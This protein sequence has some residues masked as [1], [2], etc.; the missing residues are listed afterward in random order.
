MI[1]DAIDLTRVKRALIIKLRHHGDVLLTSPVIQVLKNHAPHMEIDALVYHDTRE[2]LTNHPALH[3]LHTIDRDWKRAGVLTQW[4]QEFRLVKALLARRYDLV[5]HLTSHPRGA[6]LTRLI[7]P[8]YSVAQRGGGEGRSSRWWIN[9]FSHTYPA[10][11]A[12][13]RH[14]VETNLDALRRLGIHPSPTE[15]RLV[16]VPGEAAERKVAALMALHGIKARGF[17]HIHPTSRWLFK[18]WPPEKFAELILSLGK[19]GERVVLTAAPSEDERQMIAAIKTQLK[20]PVI[21]LT[22]SLSLKE[23]AALTAQARA[24]VGVDSA[25]M[26]IAAAMQTRT[27]A[28]FGPSGEIHWGPWAVVHRVVASTLPH[29]RCRP[30]GNDGCGGSKVSDCL[31]ELPVEH[32]RAALNDVLAMP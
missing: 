26:H 28:L 24:F 14:T 3:T 1:A 15:K 22:G 21:D 29:H 16:L 25:P 9:T 4:R 17:I 8:Q 13:F 32:V 23:L 12:T 5:I 18:T 20:A 19:S 2:M 11:R 6:W 7:R 27:V 10:P 30:C 31:Q